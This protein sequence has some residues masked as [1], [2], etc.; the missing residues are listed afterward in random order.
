MS[1]FLEIGPGR[2]DFLFW[3]ATEH[4][5]VEI[6]AIEYKKKRY[7]KLVGRLEKRGLTNVKL[8]WGDARIVLLQEFA[9][10]SLDKIFVL[11]SDPW[12]KKRH[13]KHRLFQEVFAE[14]L[15]QVL[16]PGGQLF[17]AHDDPNYIAQIRET[18]DL[19]PNLFT[20]SDEGVD[21]LTFYA[22][23]WKKEGRT[24]RSF[25]YRRA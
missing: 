14:D 1:I 11:F 6:A 20:Y 24:L 19:F 3:L 4:P 8:Y 25:S 15:A 5:D 22:D 23:K 9:E 17:I 18:F 13:A 16:K 10:K 7:D 2:G 21:F 12:P